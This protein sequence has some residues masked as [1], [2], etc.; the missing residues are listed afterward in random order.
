MGSCIPDSKTNRLIAVL[1]AP[2][3]ILEALP[4]QRQRSRAPGAPTPCTA[5]Q[6]RQAHL[7]VLLAAAAHDA[8]AGERAV[9]LDLQRRQRQAQPVVAEAGRNAVAEARQQRGLEQ[10]VVRPRVLPDR[11]PAEALRLNAGAAAPPL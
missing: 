3:E 11:L 10:R 7:A 1:L 6:P 8:E 9:E 4:A 2:R 5:A